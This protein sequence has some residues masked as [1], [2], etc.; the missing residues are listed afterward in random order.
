M[1]R[2]RADEPG[3]RTSYQCPECE[4][5]TGNLRTLHLHWMRVHPEQGHFA[6]LAEDEIEVVEE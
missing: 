2:D 4:L 1:T 6:D 5:T 3:S